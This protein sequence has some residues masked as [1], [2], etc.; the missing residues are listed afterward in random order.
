M[1]ALHTEHTVEEV[2]KDITRPKYM[3][4]YEAKEYGIIDNVLDTEEGPLLKIVQAARER[5][6]LRV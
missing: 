1:I 2:E 4:P 5:K 3:T 6:Y